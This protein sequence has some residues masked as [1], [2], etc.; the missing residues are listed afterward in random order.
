MA[1]GYRARAVAGTTAL[2][3]DGQARTQ[4]PDAADRCR[5]V[6]RTCQDQ[7]LPQVTAGTFELIH[8]QDRAMWSVRPMEA[9]AA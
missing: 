8:D 2:V 4:S 5:G 1:R 6:A 3:G 9:I 7:P